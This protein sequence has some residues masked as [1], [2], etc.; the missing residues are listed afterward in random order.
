[1]AFNPLKEKGMP[2]EKQVRNWEELTRYTYDKNQVDPYTRCRIIL[3]N[4]IEVEEAIFLHEFN[5]M[6][7]RPEIKEQLAMQRRMEQQQQKAVNGMIPGDE[8]TIEN[9][10]GYE[11]VAVDLTAFL[12]RNAIDPYVKQVMDFGLL[13][14][15]DHLYRYA[16]LMETLEGKRAEKIVRDY[17]EV[18]PGRPTMF[19]H[20]HPFD[21]LKR[22][23]NRKKADP[24][25]ILYILTLTAG[26]QQT[27][28]FYMNQANRLTDHVGRGLYT[29]IAMIEE[30]HVTQY[31]SLLDPTMD[32]F[33]M[34][35]CHEYNECYLYH[36]F[37]EQESDPKV[38]QIWELHLD[39]ELGHLKAACE[40][41]RRFAK[42]DAEAL[43]PKSLP[44]PIVFQSNIDYVRDVLESQINLTEVGTDLKPVD[45]IDSNYRYFMYQDM[46]N[47]GW[48]PSEEVIEQHVQKFRSDYR[49]E[50]T[51]G[52]R[53]GK[54]RPAR[55]YQ[56]KA[57]TKDIFS[58]L[59]KDHDETRL[60][61]EKI[62]I[63]SQGREALFS[64]LS[65]ALSLH[66]EGEEH[67]FYPKLEDSNETRDL[68]ME[69]YDEH[70]E[71]KGI[72]AEIG[73]MP[74]G[75]REW[76]SKLN[77]LQKSVE[78]H[79]K[80]EEKQLFDK[81]RSVIDEEESERIAKEFQAEKHRNMKKAG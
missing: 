45:Q 59:K 22:P 80:E 13:E 72:L 76:T 63:G 77:D 15:F 34:L 12:A 19:E 66:M 57:P 61:F 42:R 23:T 81:A 18:F 55:Y 5:R 56:Q 2:L 14:D 29:E 40:M 20:R 28:N 50:L 1:M 68:T 69:G 17:T 38:K 33:D 21:N 79:I 3:M 67:L 46:V 44:A 51:N 74:F 62:K 53:A 35:V 6:E 31:E 49:L 65:E 25:D 43:L 10:I 58:L 39:M 64:E 4:G 24:K 75:N 36:S 48:V 70:N 47:G 16:N 32:W 78:H 8:S 11:Q 27:M 41:M 73:Q 60:L 71:A 30:Q 26:E 54:I 9:T 37:M 52:E 7:K